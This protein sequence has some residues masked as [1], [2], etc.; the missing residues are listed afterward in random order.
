MPWRCLCLGIWNG[1]TLWHLLGLASFYP[2]AFASDQK[3]LSHLDKWNIVKITS[4]LRG[5][6]ECG[7][8]IIYTRKQTCH[9]PMVGPNWNPFATISSHSITT[10]PKNI[11]KEKTISQVHIRK[12][13][14]NVASW[15]FLSLLSAPPREHIENGVLKALKSMC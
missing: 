4:K 14:F 15:D 3:I 11:H 10:V 6:C 5:P 7:K 8:Q 13:T 1:L 9:N 12:R 2:F